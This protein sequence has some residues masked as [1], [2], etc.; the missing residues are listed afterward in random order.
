[1]ANEALTSP[2]VDSVNLTRPRTCE[3]GKSNPDARGAWLGVSGRIVM[4]DALPQVGG[5]D[6]LVCE[7]P[8]QA[9]GAL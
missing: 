1:M 8:A 6:S 7:G 3:G 5:S 2:N 4:T 9:W